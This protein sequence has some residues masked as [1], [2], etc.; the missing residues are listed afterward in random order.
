MGVVGCGQRHLRGA[1]RCVLLAC[2][3][4]ILRLFTNFYLHRKV[5][6]FLRNNCGC[7]AVDLYNAR[8]RYAVIDSLNL[9]RNIHWLASCFSKIKKPIRNFS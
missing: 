3:E 6:I 9:M 8:K 7:K 1:Q 2:I 4:G 5:S